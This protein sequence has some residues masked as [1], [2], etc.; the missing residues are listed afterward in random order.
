MLDAEGTTKEPPGRAGLKSAVLVLRTREGW[1]HPLWERF[2]L[3]N[4]YKISVA[5]GSFSVPAVLTHVNAWI[6]TIQ[7]THHQHC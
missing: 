2:T 7:K 3:T 4:Q 6:P 5:I 1:V